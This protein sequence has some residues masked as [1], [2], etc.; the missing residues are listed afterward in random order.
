MAG[1]FGYSHTTGGYDGG[2]AEYV[3]VPFADVGPYII[4]EDIDV[5]DA[6]LLA[7][8]YPTGY[9]AAE[10]ADRINVFEGIIDDLSHGIRPRML[11]ERGWR[12]DKKFKTRR[13][14]KVL[15]L[16]GLAVAL[17]LFFLI[18]KARTS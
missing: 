10:M 4:P 3:R 18:K 11:E 2:Q 7:D 9:Q 16:T 12:M 8:A 17:P 5:D 14:Y 6:V 13:Y 15:G 1:F